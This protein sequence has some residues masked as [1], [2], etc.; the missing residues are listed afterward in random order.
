MESIAGNKPIPNLPKAGIVAAIIVA[1]IFPLAMILLLKHSPLSF[2]NKFYCSRL[3]FW[4]EVGL[5]WLYAHKVE[6]QGLLIWPAKKQGIEFLA[7]AVIILYLLSIAA[8]FVAAIPAV[9]GYHEDNK[10]IKVIA[11]LVKGRPV[12]IVF[13]S[14]TAGVCEE[15]IFRGFILTRLALYFKNSYLPIILSSLLFAGMHYGYNSL[16]EYIFSFLIGIIMSV[17]YQ[18]YG[19][20]RPLI[21]VHFLIDLVGLLLVSHYVK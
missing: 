1:F 7:S 6:R 2:W 17:H 20:I 8:Q 10:L 9:L 18:R 16:R 3:I 19:D 14:I 11:A 15:L 12:L 13:V 21:I 5:L 4:V